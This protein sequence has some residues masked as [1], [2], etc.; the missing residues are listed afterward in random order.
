MDEIPAR[1]SLVIFFNKKKIN[2]FDRS[3]NSLG[4]ISITV[5]GIDNYKMHLLK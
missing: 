2:P 1:K 4:E 5:E 3:R